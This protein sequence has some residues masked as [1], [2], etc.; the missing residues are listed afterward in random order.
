MEH[1]GRPGVERPVALL[2]AAQLHLD[3]RSI[4]DVVQ[5]EQ[6]PLHPALQRAQRRAANLDRHAVGQ[7]D[8][9][10]RA[11]LACHTYLPCQQCAA[12]AGRIQGPA[13]RDLSNLQQGHCGRVDVDDIAARVNDDHALAHA[14]DQL[15]SR[16]GHDAQQPQPQ[17]RP[18]QQHAGQ[19]KC[20]RRQIEPRPREEIEKVD[21]VRCPGNRHSNE[22]HDGLQPIATDA[23]GRVAQEQE[24]TEKDQHIEIR[25]KEPEERAMCIVVLDPVGGLHQAHVGPE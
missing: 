6:R 23:A 10:S 17:D 8:L 13:I 5:Q 22:D 19:G 11:F 14:L 15:G 16:H 20:H 9:D 2:A 12:F 7:C 3:A 25:R 18:G 24:R 1:G 21:K 4:R